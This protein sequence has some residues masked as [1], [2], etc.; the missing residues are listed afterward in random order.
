[1]TD[2]EAPE[3]RGARTDRN[4]V[5]GRSEL[6]QDAIVV[7]Q[8]FACREVTERV[9]CSA[10]AVLAEVVQSRSLQAWRTHLAEG[11]KR[12]ERRSRSL[13]ICVLTR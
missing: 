3:D 2:G 12:M 7:T 9:K 11:M 13:M 4:T 1:M 5:S 10:F 6:S 8:S